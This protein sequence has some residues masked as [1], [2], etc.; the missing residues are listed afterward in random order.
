MK[1]WMTLSL[2]LILYFSYGFHL[3]QQEI[4]IIPTK[5]TQGNRDG[6]YDYRGVL[7]VHT[8]LSIGSSPAPVIIEAAKNA[9]LDFVMLT[10][11]NLFQRTEGVEAYHGNTLVMLGSK[12]SY[13]DARV[14]HYS[15]RGHAL[16][17]NLGEAQVKIADLLSQNADANVDDLLYLAHPSKAGFSWSGEFPRGFDGFELLNEKSLS[18]RA[19]A[20]SKLSTI[21]SLFTYPFNPNLAFVRLFNEPTEEIELLRRLS[22]QRPVSI[23]AGAEAS[24]RAVPLANYLIKFPSY[25]RSFEFL[26]THVLLTSELTGNASGDRAKIFQALK[27]GNTYLCFESL[28]DPTGFLAVLDDRNRLH[29]PGS[30]VK[31]SPGM[32]LKVSLPAEPKSFFEIVVLRNGERI[33]TLNET[34]IEVPITAP[35]SYRV[36]V[37]VSPYLPLP[38]AIRWMTW[39]YT[40]SFWVSP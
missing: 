3:S 19:W 23:F 5:L 9:G 39:I 30:R 28:G 33:H 4:S 16:G 21:W 37:R 29:L 22:P 12:I 35:G 27:R 32:T 17:S 34:Q 18:H 26:T 20:S 6:F 15:I 36:Q 25:Q 8:D 10:D 31:L 11:L 14:I 24:A 7:N 13:L 40:N 2:C 1:L 38:D